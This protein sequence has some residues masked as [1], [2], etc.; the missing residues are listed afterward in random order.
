MKALFKDIFEDVLI[1]FDKGR[2]YFAMTII[3]GIIVKIE[4]GNS[5]LTFMVVIPMGVLSALLGLQIYFDSLKM[6]LINSQKNLI[7]LTFNQYCLYSEGVKDALSKLKN[8]RYEEAIQL[9]SDLDEES[10]AA[11]N[12]MKSAN[13]GSINS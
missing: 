1:C 13:N 7:N 4:S 8:G 9:I 12:I 11:I 6:R 2:S 10:T 3:V 5:F